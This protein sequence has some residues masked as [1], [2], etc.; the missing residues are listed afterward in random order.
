MAQVAK[1]QAGLRIIG[2]DLIPDE[3]TELLGCPPTAAQ[4]KGEELV[5]P[6]TGRVRIAKFGMWRLRATVCQPEDLDGQVSELLDQL[7]DDPDVW[8]NL[9]SRFKMDLFVGFF[10]QDTNEGC[11]VSPETLHKL[12]QRGIALGLDIYGP[13]GD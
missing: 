2:D 4:F 1:S 12:G 9:A 11:V 6:K 13:P 10:L 3:V 5:V 8:N 7:S